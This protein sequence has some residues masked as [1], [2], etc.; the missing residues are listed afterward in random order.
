MVVGRGEQ[1]CVHARV[2]VC[3]T[4]HHMDTHAPGWSSRCCCCRRRARPCS[5]GL[6]PAPHRSPVGVGV[7]V[8]VSRRFVVRGVLGN[9]GC[10]VAK[11]GL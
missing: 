5:G 8:V 4:W 9:R 11:G 1:G 6:P 7:M 2:R 10:C 3:V